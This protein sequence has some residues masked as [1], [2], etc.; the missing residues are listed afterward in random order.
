MVFLRERIK[1]NPPPE[2]MPMASRPTLL[3]GTIN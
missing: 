2:K 1:P 3:S